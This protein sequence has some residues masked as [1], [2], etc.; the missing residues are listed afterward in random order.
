MAANATVTLLYGAKDE[1][2]NHAAVLTDHLG[3]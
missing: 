1:T 2:V 3:R